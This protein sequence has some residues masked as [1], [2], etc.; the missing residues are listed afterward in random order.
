MEFSLNA[1]EWNSVFAVPSSIVDR[2]L[3]LAGEDS[4]KLILF[5]LRHGGER[6]TAER[7]RMEL[8]FKRVGELEDAAL[9]WV[10]RGV[11]RAESGVLTPTGTENAPISD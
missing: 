2:Y 3:L 7:L 1:G 10:E 8:G 4:L 11:V 5:L 6:F 9:C